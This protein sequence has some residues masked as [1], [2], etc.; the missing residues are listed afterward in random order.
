MSLSARRARPSK[1]QAQGRSVVYYRVADTGYPRNRRIR[2]F[3]DDAGV[4]VVVVEA[5]PLSWRGVPILLKEAGQLWRASRRAAAI[6]L[7]ETQMTYAGVA[8]VVAALRRTPL[9]VDAFVGVEESVRDQTSNAAS[10]TVLRVARML[11]S[12]ALRN[13]DAVLTDTRCRA[14]RLVQDHRLDPGRVAFLPVGA[15]RWAHEIDGREDANE[16]R[17]LYYGNYIPL[18]GTMH[19]VDALALVRRPVVATFIGDGQERAVV[20]ARVRDLDLGERVTFVDAVPES[21]LSAHLAWSHVVI[22]IFGTSEKAASV[23]ANKV[24]Q[25]LSAGRVVITRDSPA[26]SEIA[27]LVGPAL[28]VVAA[29]EPAAIARELE[30][31]E[32]SVAEDAGVAD[33][34]EQYVRARYSAGFAQIGAAL[35][36]RDCG[37]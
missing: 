22:G 10:R 26:L 18:H 14:R 6:V 12:L 27:A 23:I 33:R 35:G 24:W 34:L 21:D 16:L 2:E 8:L 1:R 17:V 31:I 20:E 13:A 29:A 37:S 11:D 30:G 7:A 19:L 4:P 32:I 3:L 36:G 25:G 5:H 15:P 28:R 9:V